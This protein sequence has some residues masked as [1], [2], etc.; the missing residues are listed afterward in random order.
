ML[1]FLQDALDVDR[2]L[3]RQNQLR[4][5]HAERFARMPFDVYKSRV[6]IVRD[7]REGRGPLEGLLRATP[8]ALALTGQTAQGASDE[9]VLAHDGVDGPLQSL[10]G[11][12]L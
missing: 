7:E 9:T 11:V 12:G 5:L 3:D 1:I 4:K 8:H 6:K 2:S 10:G